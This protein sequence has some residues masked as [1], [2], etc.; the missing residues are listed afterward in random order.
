[1][2]VRLLIGLCLLLITFSARAEWM[3]WRSGVGITV[4]EDNNVNIAS[5]GRDKLSDESVQARVRIARRY[6]LSGSQYSG[7]FLGAEADLSRREYND[8][9]GLSGWRGGATLSYQQKLGLG[10]TVPRLSLRASAHYEAP[11]DRYREHWDYRLSATG[12]F[13]LGPRVTALARGRLVE[14]QGQEWLTSSPQLS[15]NVFD[16][17]RWELGGEL[18]VRVQPWA[19]LRVR[20]EYLDGEFDAFCGPGSAG[21]LNQVAGL[22]GVKAVAFDSVFNS[23]RWLVEGDGWRY[24]TGLEFALSPSQALELHWIEH[25]IRVDTSQSY[26]RRVFG[27]EWRYAL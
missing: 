14:Q 11:D 19:R 18:R 21:R 8:F 17:S 23:C 9:D 26:E 13:P 12:I 5:R 24:E 3:D 20:A 16:Q 1:M 25:D 15:S 10:P 4:S 2:P 27:L 7:A 6:A 22:S